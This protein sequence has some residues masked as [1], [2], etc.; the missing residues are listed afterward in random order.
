MGN[1]LSHLETVGCA[2]GDQ[3]HLSAAKRTMG[4]EGEPEDITSQIRNLIRLGLQLG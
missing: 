4:I 2:A 3:H 1:G